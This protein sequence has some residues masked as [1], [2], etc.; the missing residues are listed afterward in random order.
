MDTNEFKPPSALLL[1]F[2]PLRALSDYVAGHAAPIASLPRGDGHPV[3]V[4]P[5][6]GASGAATADL[7]GRL[8]QL[9][10]EV[11]DWQQGVN[12]W[13]EDD[14]DRWILL[15]GKHLEQISA[16]RGR[17]VSLIGWSLGGIYAREVAKKHPELVRQVI[18][19]A[20]PFADKPDSTHAGW[21]VGMLNGRA[22]LMN[23]ALLKQLTI[24][25]AVPCTSVYSQ[26]DGIVA[27]QGCVGT[28][29]PRH[30][31]IEVS[32]VSHL[33]MVHH[34]EVLRVVASLLAQQY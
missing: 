15:L 26:T 13:P 10:Y 9:G 11:F 6:L 23:D 20:T 28:E 12:Q 2:E 16:R 1:A 31:N 25:P 19:L 33:G 21:L 3:I 14:F 17:P 18:T 5:G 24:D 8:Q 27:W 29:S 30:R 32:G 34:P 4:F 7:R 22:S